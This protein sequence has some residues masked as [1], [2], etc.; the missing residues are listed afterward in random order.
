MGRSPRRAFNRGH[1]VKDFFISYNSADRRWAEWLAWVLEEAGCTTV[2]QAWDFRPG[3]NFILE[4]QKA[5]SG[6]ERTIAVLSPDYL[7]ALYTQPEWAAAFAQDPTGEKGTL[8]PVRVR[9]CDLKGLL[10][11]IVHIDLAG[12]DEKSAKETLLEG[13]KRERAK[14]TVKPGFPEEVPRA[15]AERPRFP[16]ALPPVWNVPSRRN[17]NFTGRKALLENL[18]TALTS[19]KGR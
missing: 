10:A 1:S 14:P 11:P 5:A 17:P 13:V 18:R 6:A 4:M 16:G 2:L 12:R 19:G 15:V 7:K 3:C 8:L 9:E